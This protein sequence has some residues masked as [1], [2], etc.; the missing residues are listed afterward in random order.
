M[1]LCPPPAVHLAGD[2]PEGSVAL[3]LRGGHSEA[4]Q[5]GLYRPYNGPWPPALSL[6][7]LRGDSPPLP[8][9]AAA[10]NLH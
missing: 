9:V 2:L 1:R 7:T 8:A 10:L 4:V 3:E 5:M 6:M